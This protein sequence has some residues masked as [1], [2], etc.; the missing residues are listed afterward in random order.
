MRSGF[1]LC[2]VLVVALA[3][4]CAT[5][6]D[7]DTVNSRVNDNTRRIESLER[8]QE[9]RSAGSGSAQQ[10]ESLQKNVDALQKE[11]A[12]SKWTMSE[13]AGKVESF[14]AL[15]GEVQQFM[16]QYRKRG[17][18]VDKKLEQL[19]TRLEAD[20]RGLAEKLRQMLESEKGN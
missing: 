4:G 7:M 3:T 10:L 11:M 15:M 6:V 13:L 19:T 20:V 14:Q 5:A 9:Q 1:C 12:D 18:E 8:A 16:I 2:A 17:G